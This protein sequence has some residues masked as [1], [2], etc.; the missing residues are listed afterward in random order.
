VKVAKQASSEQKAKA[1][2]S[3]GGSRRLVVIDGAN[4]IFRAFFAIPSLKAP[5]GTPTNAAMGFVN[6]LNRVIEDEK[7]DL[8]AVAMDP[9][10]GSFQPK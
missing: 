6:I 2:K 4:A 10:G 8:I 3:A 7:P 9:P 1:G 5:D